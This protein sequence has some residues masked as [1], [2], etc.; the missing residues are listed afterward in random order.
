MLNNLCLLSVGHKLET[1][2]IRFVCS[3]LAFSQVRLQNV[4]SFGLKIE[5]SFNKTCHAVD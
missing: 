5:L 2:S 3:V 1:L 4:L